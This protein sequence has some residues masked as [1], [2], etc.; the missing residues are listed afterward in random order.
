M[1]TPNSTWI[2]SKLALVKPH[3]ADMA[4]HVFDKDMLSAY[5]NHLIHACTSK[6]LKQDQLA[7]LERSTEHLIGQA[8]AHDLLISNTY[9]VIAN[10]HF[11]MEGMEIPLWT[12]GR[13]DAEVLFLGCENKREQVNGKYYIVVHMRLRTGLSAGIII[14]Q[15]FT[16][17]QIS[18]FLNKHSGAKSLNPAVEEISGMKASLVLDLSGDTITVAD[19]KCNQEQRKYN[20][21]LTEARREVRK[22]SA[23]IPCNTCPKTTRECNLAIWLPEEQ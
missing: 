9:R 4:D 1:R 22:C 3:I 6:T 17:R 7:A 2:S 10:W 12:G 20:R 15:R 8:P 16:A 5:C 19:W 23:F 11:I 18:F 21:Q 13:T 14:R